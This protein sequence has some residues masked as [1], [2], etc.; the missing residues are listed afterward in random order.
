MITPKQRAYLRSLSNGLK[1]SL[2]LGKEGL[3]ETFI[4][5][6]DKALT[7]HELIKIRVLPNAS[8]EMEEIGK[9]LSKELKAEL[10]SIIGHVLTLYRKNEKKPVIALP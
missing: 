5:A 10:V 6:S 4:V 3:S 2:S 1:P 7:A 9:N 8:I